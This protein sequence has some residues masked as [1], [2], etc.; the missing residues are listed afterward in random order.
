LKTVSGE[1][2]DVNV[3]VADDWKIKL[4]QMKREKNPE[5]IFN[6]DE[7]G[8]FYRSKT[9]AFKGKCGKQCKERIT[10]LVGGNMD[11]SEKSPLS[12]IG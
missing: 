10:L 4:Q 5:D 6:A 8:L 3:Q 2:G 9:L 7:T 1:S 12:L 11:G